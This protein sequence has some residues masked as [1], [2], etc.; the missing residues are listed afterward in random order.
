M[1]FSSTV[2][3]FLFL[4]ISLSVYFLV[5][6]NLRDVWLLSASLFFYAWGE[7]HL[8]ALLFVSIIVD[9]FCGLLIAGAFN[10]TPIEALT[11]NGPRSPLQQFG[12]VLSIT[13]NLALLAVFK[14]FNFGIDSFNAFIATIGFESLQWD[15][16]LQITL[17]L[18]ISFF[19]FQSMSYT[20]DVYLGRTKATRNILKFAMFV[21]LFPQLVAG[22]IVRYRQIAGELHSRKV[23]PE[24]V[25]RGVKRFVVGLGKKMI[26]ANVVALPADQIFALPDSE[27]TASV[28]WFAVL[29]YTLQIFFDFSGYS[30]MA[31]GLG[32]MLG[33]HFPENFNY[34]YV[35]QSIREFWRRWHISLSTWFRDY[36]Y[37]P[38]GGN[39]KGAL[40]TNFNL[41]AV[42]FYA[43]CGMAPVGPLSPGDSFTGLFSCWNGL[44]SA[45]GSTGCGALSATPIQF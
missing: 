37:I 45:R 16:S 27:I 18:G 6:N 40:R 32:L 19:T 14:Y 39:K 34:P 38:L 30:D 23:T 35:A 3:V 13:A 33:F 29:C 15:T 1:V 41:I 28:A 22:P 25:A 4:P 42:F 10:R 26:I 17:P 11:E 20:I 12:L 8:V 21:A 9:Y 24:L 2:F 43:G 7:A 36:L 31:I 5:P 44:A